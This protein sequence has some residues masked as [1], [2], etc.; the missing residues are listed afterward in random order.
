MALRIR[1][2]TNFSLAILFDSLYT[3]I[4]QYT[5]YTAHCTSLQIQNHLL[6]RLG[7]YVAWT[8]NGTLDT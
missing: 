8:H 1:Y 4:N 5:S 3:N 2:R 6:E 7:I